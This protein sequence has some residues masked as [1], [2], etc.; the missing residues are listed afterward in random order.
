M[1]VIHHRRGAVE[2]NATSLASHHTSAA[3]PCTVAFVAVTG[4]LTPEAHGGPDVSGHRCAADRAHT[5]GGAD[6]SLP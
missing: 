3:Q 1:T 4:R 2:P 6:D 5:A